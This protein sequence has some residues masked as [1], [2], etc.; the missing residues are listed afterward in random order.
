[1][2]PI[3]GEKKVLALDMDKDLETKH[4]RNEAS[5]ERK[6]LQDDES[7]HAQKERLNGKKIRDDSSSEL[8]LTKKRKTYEDDATNPIS[9]SDDAYKKK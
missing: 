8:N 9:L 4:H 6:R 7:T 2:T 1:M 5:S 3:Q